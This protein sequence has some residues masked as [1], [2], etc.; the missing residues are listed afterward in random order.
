MRIA[1]VSFEYPPGIKGGAGVYANEIVDELAL[2]GHEVTVFSP[3][4][5][6]P[7][8]I[9]QGV[10]LCPVGVGSRIPMSA[11]MF[12]LHL[13]RVIRK[14]HSAKQF[15]IVHFNGIS[16]WFLRRRLVDAPQ[17]ATIHHLAI[18]AM[19]V[20]ASGRGKIQLLGEDN[21]LLQFMEL[22]CLKS[23]DRVVCVSKSTLNRVLE[24][25]APQ[26]MHKASLVY[27]GCG[28]STPSDSQ[29]PGRGITRRDLGFDTN[30]VIL[31]VGRIDDPR[32]GLDILLNAFKIVLSF[33]PAWLL[34]VG[35][36]NSKQMKK[37]AREIDVDAR[38]LFKG[39][40]DDST[41]RAC[42]EMSDLFV[43]SSRWEGFGLTVTEAMAVGTPVVATDVGSIPELIDN[44]VNGL[45]VSPGSHQALAQ[46]ILEIISD[47]ELRKRIAANGRSKCCETFSWC[48]AAQQTV[49]EYE[50]AVDHYRERKT[51]RA[52]H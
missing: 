6:P 20:G 25:Y 1:F 22:R 2:L 37:M 51:R 45:M 39:P 31:F 36:G 38:T 49:K 34:I 16:Y 32:K 10:S 4:V 8:T 7:R 48:V 19:N 18:D 40:V 5:G 21:P 47:G 30:P 35:R 41:L 9:R 42:F 50:K 24:S 12:W 33:G 23:V 44:R 46:A 11:L 15:D 3:G 43:S 14:E 28:I 27:N 13:P 52:H 29:G 17:V 26:T